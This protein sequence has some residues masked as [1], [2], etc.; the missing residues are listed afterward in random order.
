MSAD[1]E[2]SEPTELIYVP[3]GSWAPIIAAAGAALLL[4][5]FFKGWF[6]ILVGALILIAGLVAWW[7]TASDE[8]SRMRREQQADTAVVP[9]S[10]VRRS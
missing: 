7:R 10:V 9:A 8:I 6:V 2:S 4:V 1:I 5:G 3:N